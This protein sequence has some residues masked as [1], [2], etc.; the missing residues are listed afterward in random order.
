[1]KHSWRVTQTITA[2]ITDFYTVTSEETVKRDLSVPVQSSL[3]RMV[4]DFIPS[5]RSGET[6]E[7]FCD[8]EPLIAQR[9]LA[10]AAIQHHIS[11]VHHASVHCA[12]IEV[13]WF[14]TQG[15]STN[16]LGG[17]DSTFLLTIWE[18]PQS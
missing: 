11:T 8:R 1:M 13:D 16:S 10:A 17:S 14:D 4:A 2:T 3:L 18:K 7:E 5:R 6:L 9:V 12:P 15:C